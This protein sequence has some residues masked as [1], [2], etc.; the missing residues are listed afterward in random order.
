MWQRPSLMFLAFC[1]SDRRGNLPA[2]ED[3]ALLG[4]SERL[5]DIALRLPP[6]LADGARLFRL[7]DLFVVLSRRA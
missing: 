1:S 5:G 6:T 3:E 2:P 7:P 4:L